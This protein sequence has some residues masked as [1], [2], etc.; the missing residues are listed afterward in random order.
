MQD[1]VAVI[2]RQLSLLLPGFRVFLVSF[3]FSHMR[4]NARGRRRC[5]PPGHLCE[6]CHAYAWATPQADRSQ[7]V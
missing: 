1:Q 3:Q 4:P 7:T 2:K 5:R 6:S